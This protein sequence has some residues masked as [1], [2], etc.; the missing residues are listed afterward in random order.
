M[1]VVLAGSGGVLT[2]SLANPW[3]ALEVGRDEGNVLHPV[4]MEEIGAD[5]FGG[6]GSTSPL[7]QHP[8]DSCLPSVIGGSNR[9][10]A[11]FNAH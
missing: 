2:A 9:G 6:V 10:V 5:V 1:S 8:G 3:A 4:Q 7:L 11:G